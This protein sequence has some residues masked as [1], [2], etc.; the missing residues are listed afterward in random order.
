MGI[1]SHCRRYESVRS[2]E[3]A[4]SG[5]IRWRITLK[6]A[7]TPVPAK[8]NPAP[9]ATADPSLEPPHPRV[10]AN[11]LSNIAAQ[12]QGLRPQVVRTTRK[13]KGISRV[14]RVAASI[15]VPAREAA[16]MPAAPARAAARSPLIQAPR[17]KLRAPESPDP[18][19]RG[20]RAA[21]TGIPNAILA[22][23]RH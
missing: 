20:N 13:K 4:Y 22:G 16:S 12:E 9:K 7:A 19:P 23:T 17:V 14:D 15:Q 10:V 18:G 21:A 2:A 6:H 1:P 3:A 11:P 8:S 5:A